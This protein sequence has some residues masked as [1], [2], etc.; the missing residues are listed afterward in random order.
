MDRSPAQAEPWKGVPATGSLRRPKE[1]A[2]RLGISRSYFYMLVQRGELPAP[3][4]IA[5]RATGLP[6]SWLDAIVA[7][8]IAGAA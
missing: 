1:C 5:G 8:K 6:D 2:A 4:R 7:S 3:V